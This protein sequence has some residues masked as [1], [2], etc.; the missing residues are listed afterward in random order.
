MAQGPE[1]RVAERRKD[2]RRSVERGTPDR[3]HAS[4]RTAAG[5]ALALASLAVG[6]PAGADVYTRINSK[7]VLEATDVPAPFF[8]LTYRSKGTLVH[9]A[10][11]RLRASPNTEF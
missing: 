2:R 1:R 5:V 9:S 4:R 11:F 7:G 3:R 8:T 10:G 6:A